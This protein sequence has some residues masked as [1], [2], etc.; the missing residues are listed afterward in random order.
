MSVIDVYFNTIPEPAKKELERVRRIVKSAAPLAEETISYGMPAFNYK[1]KYLVG[2]AASKNHYSLHP[3]PEPIAELKDKLSKFKTSKGTI[4]FTSDN[5][6]SETM[7]KKIVAIRKRI[8]N[9]R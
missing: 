8:I 5:P 7:I 6:L 3:T 2:F 9:S 1:G 4:Q